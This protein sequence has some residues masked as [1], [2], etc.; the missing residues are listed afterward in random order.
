MSKEQWNDRDIQRALQE[1]SKV[2]DNIPKEILYQ[3]ISNSLNEHKPPKKQKVKFIPVLAT[4]IAIVLLSFIPLLIND[5]NHG[6][7]NIS[8]ESMDVNNRNESAE[9]T[10][11]EDSSEQTE[12]E[13]LMDSKQV[14]DPYVVHSV[15]NDSNIV[16][17]AIADEQS[18]YVIPLTFIVPKKDNMDDHYK[19]LDHYMMEEGFSPSDYFL[20]GASYE[21]EPENQE[22]KIQLPSDFSIT[23]SANANVF[24]GIIQTMFSPYG[25]ER[26]IFSSE[27]NEPVDLGP[28]GKGNELPIQEIDKASYKLYNNEYLVPVPHQEEK[29]IDDAVMEMKNSEEAFR[30]TETI[31]DSVDFSVDSSGN[32]LQLSYTGDLEIEDSEEMVM[33]IDAILMTAK[34]YGFETVMFNDM[35]IDSI[36]K[37]KMGESIQVPTAVNPIVK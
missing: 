33:M 22:V 14:N 24:E 21:I 19:Q 20:E 1:M 18:Q 3:R 15:G 28:I 7:N 8:L 35:G 31:P 32:D 23:S 11:S 13:E 36:G 6:A 4:L 12:D 2:K 29:N 30:L 5:P 10:M 16:Y 27:G 26:A 17:A 34:S 37:Y 9:I 25:I